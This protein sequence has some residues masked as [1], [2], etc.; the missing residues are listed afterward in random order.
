MKAARERRVPLSDAAHAVLR[1]VAPPRDDARGAWVFP[2]QRAGRPLSNRAFLMMPQHMGRG[3]LTAPGFRGKFRDWCAET[4]QPSDV[5]EA[6]LAHTL[7]NKVQA[8]YQRG[9]LLERRRKLMKDWA[10]FCARTAGSAEVM[11]ISA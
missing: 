8:A 1:A 2:G 10:G 11:L 4:G 7:G 6:A 5:A 9:D 3:D